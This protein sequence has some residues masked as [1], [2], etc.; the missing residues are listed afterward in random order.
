[1]SE[2]VE[3]TVADCRLRIQPGIHSVEMLHEAARKADLSIERVM[4]RRPGDARVTLR[5]LEPRKMVQALFTLSL[6]LENL[7][8]DMTAMTQELS[9]EV[10]ALRRDIDELGSKSGGKS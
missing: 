1:M 7:R 5:Q 4:G 9:A 10:E 3:V 6:T 2:R 8:Q